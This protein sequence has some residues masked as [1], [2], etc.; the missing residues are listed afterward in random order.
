MKK[1][2]IFFSSQWFVSCF[3]CHIFYSSFNLKRYIIRHYFLFVMCCRC[4]F[5]W[6]LFGSCLFF[7]TC[8]WCWLM[9]L[10]WFAA[11]LCRGCSPSM[12][13]RTFTIKQDHVLN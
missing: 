1:R 12:L 9:L 7:T 3:C 13:T 8:S 6:F 4:F 2:R 10:L 11:A 5:L